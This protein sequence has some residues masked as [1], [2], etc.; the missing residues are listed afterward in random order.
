MS[1]AKGRP[2]EQYF[3]NLSMTYQLDAD[4]FFGY[5]IVIDKTNNETVAPKADVVWRQPDE[6]FRGW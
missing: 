2:F 6:N 5:G 4:I 3:Y 1:F